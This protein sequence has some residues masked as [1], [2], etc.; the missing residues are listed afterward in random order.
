MSIEKQP[1]EEA[2]PMPESISWEVPEYHPH[3]RDKRWY[4]IAGTASAAILAYSLFTGNFLLAVIIILIG[5]VVLIQDA[6]EPD[7]LVFSMNHDGIMIG[8]KMYDFTELKDFAIIYRPKENTKN[9]YFEFK[10]AVKHRLTIP[11]D[12]MNPLP[13]RKFLLQYLPENKERINI[14]FSEGFGRLLKL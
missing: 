5:I 12:K 11:L 3:N 14:P 4:Y 2:L 1:S 9:L 13:I 6:Q 7:N 10:S 8:K